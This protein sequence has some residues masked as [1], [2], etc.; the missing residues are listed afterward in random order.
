MRAFRL[1]FSFVRIPRLFATLF[2]LPLL[3]SIVIVYAQLLLTGT[4]IAVS[5]QDSKKIEKRFKKR[6][7]DN[8]VRKLLY[9]DGKPLPGPQVCRWV[10]TRGANGESVEVPPSPEC[11]PDLL[12]VAI[13]AQDPA[14]Y[15]ATGYVDLFQSNTER[16]HI[17][18]TCRPDVVIDVRGAKPRADVFSIQGLLVLQMVYF[19]E[20]IASEHLEA[21]A[22]YE[23][24]ASLVG[25]RFLHSYGFKGPIKV[26]EMGTSLAFICSIA[27]LV[28]ITL[29]LAIKAHRK[30]LEYFVRNG[31]LLPM[32]AATGKRDF[33]AAIWIL[34]L[35]RV[36][37]FLVA[38][39]P[40]TILAFID[41]DKKGKLPSIFGLNDY[42]FWVWILALIASM[43]LATMIASVGDLKQRHNFLSFVYKYI[44]LI[45]CVLGALIWIFTF[46]LDGSTAA[47]VRDITASIPIIGIAPIL[48]SPVFKPSGTVL[49]MHT[50]MTV[51][52]LFALLRHNTH[53]FAAH[54]ED[55]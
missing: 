29:W 48:V 47:V 19:N 50:V 52:L 15:D 49:I 53:W 37:A 34:T 6:Q 51:L 22:S 5:N 30:V 40:L 1:A 42:Y 36:G 54:L 8:F 28:I 31:A 33:Y 46:I 10:Y 45:I 35:L 24:V 2:L 44:P 18:H 14:T 7:Q 43:G 39:V 21:A 23:Q 13:V 11:Q 17:C 32:V 25:A 55:L 9:G 38:S 27:F 20:N 16:L 12:D 26:S 41:F 3:L 4:I